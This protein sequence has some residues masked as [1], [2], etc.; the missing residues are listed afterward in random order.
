[1]A[2]PVAAGQDEIKEVASIVEEEHEDEADQGRQARESL[3]RCPAADH[4]HRTINMIGAQIV[5]VK[6]EKKKAKV[7]K[8]MATQT[9]QV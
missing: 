7:E 4:R 3:V 6:G 2:A 5:V 1:M 9:P 8:R